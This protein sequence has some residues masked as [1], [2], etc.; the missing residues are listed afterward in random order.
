VINLTP[1]SPYLPLRID[2]QLAIV[3]RTNN[4]QAVLFLCKSYDELEA[5]KDEFIRLQP[6]IKEVSHS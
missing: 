1:Y 5:Y 3:G 6:A 4:G 2:D